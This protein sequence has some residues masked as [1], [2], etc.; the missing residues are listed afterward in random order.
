[1][2]TFPNN[3]FKRFVYVHV[4]I[5]YVLSN[6]CTRDLTSAP[7]DTIRMV[8]LGIISV[9]VISRLRKEGSGGEETDTCKIGSN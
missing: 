8:K 9:N 2:A 5:P 6:I 7:R 3:R 4:Q 1:M